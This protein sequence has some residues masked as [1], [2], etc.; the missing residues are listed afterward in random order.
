MA[1]LSF[2]LQAVTKS[3]HATSVAR[4]LAKPNIKKALVSVAFARTAGVDV[5]ADSLTAL[6]KKA[7]LFVGIRNEITSKQALLQLLGYKV[8]LYIVDTGSRHVI[9]HPKIYLA[10]NTVIGEAIIGSANLTF[11]G[12][13]N[14]IEVS[15]H[16][17]LDLTQAD[18]SKFF[19]SISSSFEKMIVDHP[20]HVVRIKTAAEIEALFTAGR[21]EDEA[22]IR[23]PR[24]NGTTGGKD[25]LPAMSLFRKSSPK[26]KLP[27]LPKAKSAPKAAAPQFNPTAGT[28]YLVWESKPLSERD[29][30]IPKNAK[31]NP[32]GS[33]GL[34]KGLYDDIDHRHHFHDT[35]FAGLTWTSDKPGAT[36]LRAVAQFELIISNVNYG[37]FNLPI[38][39]GTDTKSKS[40]LQGN[41][42]TQIHWADAKQFVAKEHLLGRS[43]LLY[44][45]DSTPPEFVIEID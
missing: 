13:H 23:A 1:S 45:K 29:L 16:V 11:N 31:T 2:L 17:M 41:M 44:R 4:L 28:P 39:H 10:T 8:E 35:I 30:N 33:I 21:L 24:P 26:P 5:I 27:A 38:S 36:K 37:K 34:K 20:D 22:I 19:D 40:Y 9:F 32:T 42:M 15:T 18:D 3:N 6:G 25:A 14:N 12:L 7:K 43:L